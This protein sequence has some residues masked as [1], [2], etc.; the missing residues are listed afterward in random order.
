MVYG[1]ILCYLIWFVKAPWWLMV[2]AVT[3]AIFG[4]LKNITDIYEEGKRKGQ[5]DG[6][7]KL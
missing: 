3:G 7:N 4:A 5:K 6:Q 2:P 1:L